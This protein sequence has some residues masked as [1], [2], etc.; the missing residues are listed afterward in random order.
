MDTSFVFRSDFCFRVLCVCFPPSSSRI[1]ERAF[2]LDAS[3]EKKKKK[4]SRKATRDFTILELF[5]LAIYVMH[6][7]KQETF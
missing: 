4:A 5:L 1:R 6:S 2:L 7:G 3:L